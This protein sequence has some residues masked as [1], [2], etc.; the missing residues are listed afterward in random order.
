MIY[1]AKRKTTKG[2]KPTDRQQARQQARR[3]DLQP[4]TRDGLH[5]SAG[6]DLYTPAHGA[7]RTAPHRAQ[8][9]AQRTADAD[10]APR[11]SPR[12]SPHNRREQ[13]ND[14]SKRR[15]PQQRHRTPTPLPGMGGTRITRAGGGEAHVGGVA[16][17]QMA[18][19]PS[20]SSG[21][22]VRRPHVGDRVVNVS[23]RG[24]W[25]VGVVVFIVPCGVQP[26]AWCSRR[27]FPGL[28]HASSAPTCR[29]RYV[30]RSGGV[31]YTPEKVE[32]H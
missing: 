17:T 18:F 5:P 11:K 10:A 31:L 25:H 19:S 7:P 30:V 21:K 14:A 28:F 3:A 8:L 22:S 16:H 24:R 12:T 15:A 29:E 32:V 9:R 23:G 20:A 26:R 4:I 1:T 2:C 6:L 13:T 27:G